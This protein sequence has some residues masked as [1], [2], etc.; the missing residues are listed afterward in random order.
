MKNFN[1][2]INNKKIIAKEG[3]RV[4]KLAQKE[5][6]YIPALCFHCDLIPHES[7]RL[8]MVEVRGEKGLKT[9]CSLIA[10]S[11]MRIYTNTP[12]VKKVLKTNLELLFAQHEGKCE[13]C[14]RQENCK[15]RE[16]AEKI[17]FDAKKYPD[18][19]KNYPKYQFGPSIVLRQDKCINCENCSEMCAKQ[20]K[21]GFLTIKEGK[22]DFS[23]SPSKE[24]NSD[25]IYCGQ[26]VVHCP[27]GALSEVE[28]YLEVKKLL[29]DPK[30]KVVFQFAPSVRTSL[31]EEFGM[32]L[33]TNVTDKIFSGLKKI[34]AYKVFDTSFGADVTIIEEA[35][36][37]LGKIKKNDATTMISSCC[38]AWVKYC[39]FYEPKLAKYLTSVRSPQ[40]IVGGLI[41][42]YWA[43]KEKLNP[44]DI[45]SVSVM[46]CT[47]KKFEIRREE[48]KVDGK[49]TIDYVLT[50]RE[51]AKLL[52]GFKVD[53]A[54][55]K[56][57]NSKKELLASPSGAGE[58][59]GASG[60]VLEAALR[61]VY[62]NLTGQE[63]KNLEFKPLHQFERTKFAEVSVG[64]KTLKVV[65]VSGME[66]AKKILEEVKKDPTK[67]A[68]VEIMACPGGCI[69]G[70]GQPIP[71]D[72]D[73]RKARAQGLYSSDEKR[74]IRTSHGNPGIDVLYN[75]FL[76]D[77]K[78]RKKICHTRF[79]IRKRGKI[80]KK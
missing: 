25:C 52:K 23:I 71:V 56:P 66:N 79:I 15:L 42:T 65:A 50:V 11:G 44:K 26:C 14:S 19:K 78:N 45:V 13:N 40:I 28:D 73:I 75:E 6:I 46:P 54:K 16:L 4:L 18:R 69:G 55:I 31:G 70:G 80:I 36:E 43:K 29:K 62:K 32:P 59:F 20:T 27:V 72:N 77:D 53:L 38:P 7:C 24:K 1:I 10:K 22:Y 37:L 57:D 12:L 33:G 58:I 67:Y 64:N 3:D 21:N 49:N 8:C 61:T 60:G 41:K 39:E 9:A 5:K 51:F 30:K 63:L 2:Y 35:R 47:A 17:S 74:T 48:L 76:N 34:G 68:Y